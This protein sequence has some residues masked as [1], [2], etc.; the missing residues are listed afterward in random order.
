[1]I[2][3]LEKSH[4]HENGWYKGVISRY[5]KRDNKLVIFVIFDKQPEE[6]FLMVVPI[7]HKRDSR[8]ADLARKLWLLTKEQDID[9]SYLPDTHVKAKLKRGSDNR[10]YIC[11]ILL[12]KDYYQSLEEEGDEEYLDEDEDYSYE[13]GGEE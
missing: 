9:L 8:L 12:D 11:N 3:K 4:L 5:V 1:M 6:E 2:I 7:S 13:C 10:F